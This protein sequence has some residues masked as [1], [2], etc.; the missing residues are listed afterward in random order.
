MLNCEICGR[1]FKNTQGLAGHLRLRHAVQ[2][3]ALTLAGQPLYHKVLQHLADKL[4]EKLADA[5]LEAHGQELLKGSIE[6]LSHQGLALSLLDERRVDKAIIVAA[7]QSPRLL[8]LTS[9][10]PHCLLRV[11]NKT[12]MERALDALRSCGINYIVVVRGYQGK[13]IN[14]S[15]IRYFENIGYEN[16]GILSSLF[17]AEGE[18]NDGFVFSYSDIIY[19]TDVLQKLLKDESDIS[20]VVDTEWMNHYH[21][22]HQHPQEE[23]ELTMVEGNRITRIGKNIANPLEAK[24][25]FIGLAKFTKRGAEILRSNYARVLSECRGKPF[26]NAPSVEEAYFTDM[27]QEIID[28]GYIVHNV[29]IQG[30][31]VEIDTIEDLERAR[32][33]FSPN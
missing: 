22:R 9:N 16:N 17:C 19:G 2:K 7:G 14:Y 15:H 11:G 13:K 4:A 25:E 32:G 28:K 18:I 33:Q 3:P 24:G 29:D 6:E 20:L 5:I 21:Q 31:W 1:T 23:A 27:I 8:P 26:H 12:I 30:G 10:K